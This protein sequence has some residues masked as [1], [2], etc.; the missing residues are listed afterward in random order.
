MWIP[1]PTHIFN[2]KINTF[3]SN[4][5]FL[6]PHFFCQIKILIHCHDA[7]ISRSVVLPL[8]TLASTQF[9]SSLSLS[10]IYLLHPFDLFFIH[11][12]K[13]LMFGEDDVQIC[14]KP[15]TRLHWSRSRSIMRAIASQCEPPRI[16]KMVV[17]SK[18]E[19][20]CTSVSL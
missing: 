10:I 18:D 6:P 11:S 5:N 2:Y 4:P 8:A 9:I 3:I 20:T 1:D 16:I 14:P 7:S 17:V 12:I 15:Q 19:T 13:T